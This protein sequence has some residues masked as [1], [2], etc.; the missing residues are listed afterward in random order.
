MKLLRT[1]KTSLKKNS[2]T[3]GSLHKFQ[4]ILPRSSL[5]T[6]CKLFMQSQLDY[7][8]MIYDQTYNSS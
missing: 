7:G 5:L 6:L 1:Y 3:M 4:P 2:K 8:D